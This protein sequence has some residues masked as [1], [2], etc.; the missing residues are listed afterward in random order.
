MLYSAYFVDDQTHNPFEGFNRVANRNRKLDGIR[1]LNDNACSRSTETSDKLEAKTMNW[2]WTHTQGFVLAALLICSQNPVFSQ[3]EQSGF[4]PNFT[5]GP[6]TD[7]RN[8]YG[9]VVQEVFSRGQNAIGRAGEAATRSLNAGGPTRQPFAPASTALRNGF[10]PQAAAANQNIQQQVREQIQ[11]RVPAAAQQNLAPIQGQLQQQASRQVAPGPLTNRPAYAVPQN[12]ES[13]YVTGQYGNAQYV[14]NPQYGNA[15]YGT[16]QYGNAQYSGQISNQYYQAPVAAGGQN[17]QFGAGAQTFQQP[18]GFV[19][20]PAVASPVVQQPVFQDVAPAA[21]F[22]GGGFSSGEFSVGQSYLATRPVRSKFSNALSRIANSRPGV[23]RVWGLNAIAFGGRNFNDDSRLLATSTT[24]PADTLST[25]DA[26]ISDF[27]GFEASVIQRN[28]NGRGVGLRY[29][30]LFDN[31]RFASL[32]GFQNTYSLVGLANVVTS[33]GDGNDLF[34]VNG[35]QGVERGSNIT[36]FEVNWLERTIDTFFGIPVAY[37]ENLI[38][39][40]YFGFDEDLVYGNSFQQV[41]NGASAVQYRSDAR[42]DLF[43]VQIGQRADMPLT[44][45]FGLT[46]LGK[47]GV[48]NNRARTAQNFRTLD[49][50]GNFIETATVANKGNVPYDFNDQKDSLAFLGEAELGAYYQV[51]QNMRLKIGYRA[52]GVSGL[53]LAD[54][55]IPA[56]FY[57]PN[58]ANFADTDGDMILQ[59]GFF[60]FEFVR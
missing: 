42:N 23:N 55:Q 36:N 33:S 14:P 54:R 20:G 8:P 52:I 37:K 28:A 49:S 38:G 3:T 5:P 12:G 39:L 22:D 31:D 50:G 35:T 58:V 60:G 29:F 40:R 24:N 6:L 32:P 19:Q 45:R 10:A 53:A 1:N 47:F 17:V 41:F 26:D 4:A 57:Q 27:G 13:T 7:G 56:R 2:K 16:A 51:R 15:Q 46:F 48:F 25:G 30:G 18:Q 11:R 9:S 21:G 34:N 44:Q 43:G 59:G